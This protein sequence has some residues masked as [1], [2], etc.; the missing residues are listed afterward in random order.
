MLAGLVI[1]DALLKACAWLFLRG[2]DIPVRYSGPLRLGYVENVSGFGFEQT[3]LLARYGIAIDDAFVV[4]TLA[5]FLILALV[6]FLWRRIEAKFW[7]KALAAAAAYFIAA[8]IALALHDV[9]HV[10]LSP[11]LR[12]ILRALGPTAFAIVLYIEMEKPY[13][14]TLSLLFL[15]GTIG[16]CA[17]L[18]LPPFAVID[19]LGMYRPSIEAY[20]YAD[21]ADFYLVAA[22]VMFVLIPVYLVA[23]RLVSGR[24]LTRS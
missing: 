19:F 24:S 17:S 8:T 23:R 21:T 20:V 16:N 9:I 13:Y 6:V 11:Y 15:A 18:V 3:R 10:E 2:R 4:C 12:G 7:I 14:S 1:L 22:I 5:A